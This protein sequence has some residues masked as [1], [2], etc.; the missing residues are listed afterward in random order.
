ML[1]VKRDNPDLDIRFVF[2]KP[3]LTIYKG[4]KTTYAQ[5][6]EKHG[7]PWCSFYDLPIEWIT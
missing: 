4:S 7:F 5:W 1:A 6:C 3:F 2:Q